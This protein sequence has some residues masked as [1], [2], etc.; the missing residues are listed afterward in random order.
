M[1][2]VIINQVYSSVAQLVLFSM[3]RNE[4]HKLNANIFVMFCRKSSGLGPAVI[5]EITSVCLERDGSCHIVY[6]VLC[7][8]VVF[9][10]LFIYDFYYL[11]DL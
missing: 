6:M 2:I 7:S 8:G 5:M 9:F 3:Q 11:L 1:F 4:S 10:N